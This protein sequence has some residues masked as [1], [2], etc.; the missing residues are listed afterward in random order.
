MSEPREAQTPM[1]FESRVFQLAKDPEHA[2]ENQDA[3]RIE[4]AGRCVAIADGV[5]SGIFSRQW[6]RILV[7]AVVAD[8]PDPQNREAFGRWLDARRRTWQDEIDTSA[9]AWFQKPKLREGAFSTLLWVR[10]VEAGPDDGPQAAGCRLQGAAVGDSCL[11]WVRDGRTIRSFPLE[12]AEQL[13]ASPVVVGSVDL[14]RDELVEFASICEP[15]QEGDLLVLSTDAVAEWVF[16]REAS[17]SPPCWDDYWNMT[18]EDWQQEVDSLRSEREMRYDDATLVLLRAVRQAATATPEA[19][20]PPLPADGEDDWGEKLKHFSEQVVDEVSEQV[21][22]G[23]K[24][25]KHVKES[26]ESALKKY[27]DKLREDR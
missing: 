18:E 2:E 9:L 17:G 21:S 26:A 13:E 15:C 25:L 1:Q 22:R 14:G 11:F 10:L 20:P 16:R 23:V 4:A 8:A 6:A 12:N 5:A 7:E 24:R 3:Y 27:R 19:S